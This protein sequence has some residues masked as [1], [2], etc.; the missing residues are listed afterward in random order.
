MSCRSK[1]TP[2]NRPQLLDM[3]VLTA[4]SEVPSAGQFRPCY[5][6]LANKPTYHAS[7]ID[8]NKFNTR[9]L[10]ALD[11]YPTLEVATERMRRVHLYTSENHLA[12]R[13]V[14]ENNQREYYRNYTKSVGDALLVMLSSDYTVEELKPLVYGAIQVGIDVHGSMTAGVSSSGTNG[15]RNGWELGLMV[16]G[17]LIAPEILE[18]WITLEGYPNLRAFRQWGYVDQDFLDYGTGFTQ[19]MMGFPQFASR[20]VPWSLNPSGST[21]G[22]V[23]SWNGHSYQRNHTACAFTTAMVAWIMGINNEIGIPALFDYIDRYVKADT[24]YG[25]PSY[26]DPLG[27]HSILVNPG[28]NDPT[29]RMR[30]A[31]VAYRE[32]FGPIWSN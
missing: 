31:Y 14:P 2:S 9:R 28:T 11:G 4:V 24:E 22:P 8:W 5:V 27:S 17:W 3:A 12:T 6:G 18:S 7:D 32:G 25:D 16:A 20:Y 10:P 29:T 15:N 30:D 19:E 1:S 21:E 26:E 23:A 13:V